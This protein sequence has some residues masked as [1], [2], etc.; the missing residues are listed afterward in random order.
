MRVAD[1]DSRDVAV[2]PGRAPADLHAAADLPLQPLLVQPDVSADMQEDVLEMEY[3]QHLAEHARVDEVARYDYYDAVPAVRALLE[4]ELYA[5][6][7]PA[8][9]DAVLMDDTHDDGTIQQAEDQVLVMHWAEE[10]E[11][12]ERL[13]R[14]VGE[15]HRTTFERTCSICW[16][17]LPFGADG[18]TTV[19]LGCHSSHQF[20]ATCVAGAW[21][22]APSAARALPALSHACFAR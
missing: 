2:I 1:E 13:R 12:A 15:L 22:V 14:H 3:L 9:E 8:D 17:T 10:A 20:C 19:T 4:A 18:R 11:R 6:P 7:V 21:R 5:E 16:E